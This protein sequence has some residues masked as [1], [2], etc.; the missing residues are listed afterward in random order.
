MRI[1]SGKLK[2]K[3]IFLP[4][5]DK[6]RPLRDLVKESIFNLINHSNK[7]NITIKGAN[8]LDLFSGTGSFGLECL[9]R[10]ANKVIFVESYSE[11]LK[12]LKKNIEL[13]KIHKRT[14]IINENCF[15]F[16]NF[17]KNFND[18]FDIIFIDPPYKEEKI[19]LLINIIKDEKILKKEGILIIHRHKKDKIIISNRVKIIDER[20]YGISKIMIGR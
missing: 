17:K 20:N 19:N 10:D 15:N 11:A 16:T 1:I 12:V 2:G 4:E 3:K 9:S 18:K 8:V 13:F 14:S 6:T 5:N 7:F